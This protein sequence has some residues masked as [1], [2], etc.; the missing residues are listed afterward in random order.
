MYFESISFIFTKNTYVST[1]FLCLF[2][3]HRLS[4][5]I[6]SLHFLFHSTKLSVVKGLL[7]IVSYSFAHSLACSFTLTR[8]IIISFPKQ[9][10][11]NQNQHIL[12][13]FHE[14]IKNEYFRNE[15]PKRNFMEFKIYDYMHY[16]NGGFSFSF[17]WNPI[18]FFLF[19]HFNESI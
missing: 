4:F 7:W 17:T 19:Y 8:S 14:T 18:V 10:I 13:I 6:F 15:Y 16:S 9:A 1:H 12:L 2:A 11:S 5:G 3:S